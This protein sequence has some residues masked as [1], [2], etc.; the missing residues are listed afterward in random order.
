MNYLS[1]APGYDP[2]P[3]ADLTEF[4]RW[5]PALHVIG[6]DILIPAHGVYWPIMLHA[7]GFSDDEIPTFLVHGWWNSSGEKMSKTLGNSRRSRRARR[8]V[9]RGGVALLPDER[10]RHGP[11]CGFQR[12]TAD[13]TLQHR[14][15]QQPRQPAQ[16][17][18]EHGAQIPRRSFTCD[19]DDASARSKHAFDGAMDGIQVN[20]ALDA[21]HRRGSAGNQIVDATA[22]W[23]LAKDPAQSE[24]L[25]EFFYGMCE[26]CA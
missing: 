26:R 4:R 16:P 5:W 20:H 21:R 10:H 23:K 14:P 25:D 12:G 13:P 1:F 22:P 17:H 8:P 7:L 18:V 3:G 19:L 24:K 15:R 11:G 6:K 2:A 9:R